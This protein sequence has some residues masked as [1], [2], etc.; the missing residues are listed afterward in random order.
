MDHSATN[1]DNQS[2]YTPVQDNIHKPDTIEKLEG[3]TDMADDA[4]LLRIIKKREE[5]YKKYFEDLQKVS[6]EGKEYYFGTNVKK[7]DLYE[8]ETPIVI[9]RILASI[10]TI[11]PIVTQKIPEIDITA[12]PQNN[13]NSKLQHKIQQRLHNYWSRD[14]KMQQKMESGL[15][16]LAMDRYACFKMYYD[17]KTND[18]KVQL[19][20]AGKILF[21]DKIPSKEE[22]PFLIE[23]VDMTL[24]E[25]KK[26]YPDKEKEIMTQIQGESTTGDDSIVTVTQYWE[27]DK[28]V[29]K[30]KDLLL[31][32]IRTPYW[33]F[34][35]SADNEEQTE[36]EQQAQTPLPPFTE[37]HL[38]Q[39]TLPYFFFNLY[40]IGE[41]L[42]DEVS[43]VELVKTIQDNINKRKRQIEQNAGMAN[44]QLVGAGNKIS[45]KDFSGIKNTPEEKIWLENVD[46]ATNAIIKLTGRAIDQ[47]IILDLNESEGEIDN[48][49]GTHSSIRG[50]KQSGETKASVMILK[51]SDQSRQQTIVRAIERL[52]DDM[53]NFA[54]Q[55]MF[56]FFDDDHENYPEME[57][58][59]QFG[60]TS[61]IQKIDVINREEFRD[62]SFYAQVIEGSVTPRDKD[63]MK[64][65]AMELANNKQ[66]SLLDLYRILE[67]PDPEK[68][69]RNAIMEQT[70][71]MYLYKEAMQ[72]DS[73]DIQA[74]MDIKNYLNKPVGDNMQPA[75]MTG[76]PPKDPQGLQKYLD[77]LVSYL[78]GEEIDDDLG[79]LPYSGLHNDVQMQIQNYVNKVK[80]LAQKMIAV[81]Q[82]QQSMMGQQP[83]QQA[84]GGQAPQQK[85]PPV[86]PQG[87]PIP[88]VGASSLSGQDMGIQ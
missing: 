54:I 65:Q 72:G 2:Q 28:C 3:N 84:Q 71:P 24:G 40:G 42:T 41:S 38:A 70:N 17:E 55:C 69:A 31:G 14:W 20:P 48:V 27:P 11:I 23:Y 83:Q 61:E 44:G 77:T 57:E 74:I 86:P 50:E 32:K 19:L 18:I 52:A 66:M 60:T 22:L 56:V 47:S 78:K 63:Y 81:M 9:N 33:N 64:Q 79:E 39:P 46:D 34:D 37:N 80:D 10:E 25:L 21:P 76:I 1:D 85:A 4:E 43:M 51:Q 88:P 16:R 45:K 26:A 75:S 73:I 12:I 82:D 62:V 67:Y 7:D 35:D 36:G 59:V 87:N 58:Q 68:M 8:G 13:K 5:K 6:R 29:W 30:Y 53:Y 49:L 15:R